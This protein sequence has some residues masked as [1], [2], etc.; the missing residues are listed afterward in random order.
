MVS[1]SASVG[2]RSAHTLRTIKK[3]KEA[4]CQKTF[5]Q[6]GPRTRGRE[7]KKGEIERLCQWA[8]QSKRRVA[9]QGPNLKE[10]WVRREIVGGAEQGTP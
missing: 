10:D 2:G 7:N 6:G 8:A 1:G 9:V 5:R 4:I 3:A